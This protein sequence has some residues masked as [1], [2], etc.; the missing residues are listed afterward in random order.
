MIHGTSYIETADTPTTRGDDVHATL[1]EVAAALSEEEGRTITAQE[2]RAIEF[3][4]LRKLRRM[5]AAMG[6]TSMNMLPGD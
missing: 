2:V 3:M 6:L 5:L 1:E 4:A